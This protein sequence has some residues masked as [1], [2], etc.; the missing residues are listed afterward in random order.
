MFWIGEIKEN[1]Y[2][3]FGRGNQKEGH[4]YYMM[5]LTMETTL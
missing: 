3:I 1:K 5:E 2:D 4:M